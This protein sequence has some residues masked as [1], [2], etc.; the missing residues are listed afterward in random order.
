MKGVD[1]FCPYCRHLLV[2]RRDGELF[3]QYCYNCGRQFV[4]KEILKA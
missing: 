3:S 2:D 1:W 4:I